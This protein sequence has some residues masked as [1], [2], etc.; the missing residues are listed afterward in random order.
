MGPQNNSVRTA[1]AMDVV[2][3]VP[4]SAEPAAPN[5]ATEQA[6]KKAKPAPQP[7]QPPKT[8]NPNVTAAI[9]ATVMI[10]LGLGLMAVLAYLKQNHQL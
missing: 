2:A 7:K 1:P 3:P 4:A 5:E 10:V 8:K 6:A 9:I